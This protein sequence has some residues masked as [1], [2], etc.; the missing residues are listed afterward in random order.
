MTDF[1]PLSPKAKADDCRKP[2]LHT[3]ARGG[4]R[5][6]AALVLACGLWT[7][8]GFTVDAHAD[9]RPGS[10]QTLR[11]ALFLG[12][13]DDSRTLNAPPV[14]RFSSDDGDGFVLDRSQS[15][16]LLRFDDRHEVW[17]LMASH[18]A[19]GDIIYKDDTGRQILRAT[20]TG[21]LTLF[22]AERP[23]GAPVALE[24]KAQPI[25]LVGPMS[26]AALLQRLAQASARASRAAQKLITFDAEDVTPES[27]Y[28]YADT[29][30]LAA[31]AVVRLSKRPD[32]KAAMAR[33]GRILLMEGRRIE[34][35]QK[36]QD[37]RISIVVDDGLAGRPSSE[38]ILNA[39]DH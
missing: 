13:P 15:A 11:D 39:F 14:A 2:P 27:S 36:G 22:T 32:S 18:A 25:R 6:G 37:L 17:V 34:V 12:R 20:Q 16:P 24:G 31:D 8:L 5:K 19:R 21:G 4:I 9:E 29:A 38:R 3:A 23:A 28:L 7:A 35:R 26:P 1:M 10:L 33:L 30:A